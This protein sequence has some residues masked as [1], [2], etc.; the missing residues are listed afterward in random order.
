LIV[1]VAQVVLNTAELDAAAT[2]WLEAGFETSFRAEGLAN[3]PAKAPFQAAARER[4]DM[5]HLA[6]AARPAVELTRYEGAPPRGATVYTLDE[7]AVRVAAWNPAASAKFW[8]ALRFS[9]AG[10]G[11][12]ESSAPLP[13]WKLAVVLEAAD[14]VPEVTSV[15]AEGCV[16]VTALSTSVDSDLRALERSGLLLRSTPSWSEKVAGRELTVA[17]VEGPSGELVELL[18]TPPR[19]G[20]D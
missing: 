4:L 10:D 13:A 14:P 9:D 18:Q 1:G 7:G 17:F 6:A 16:L 8:G 3:H 12:L 15:D 11:R 2:P 5:V 20:D 19:R